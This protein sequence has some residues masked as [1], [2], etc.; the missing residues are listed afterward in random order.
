VAQSAT[1]RSGAIVFMTQNLAAAPTAWQLK[2]AHPTTGVVNV[3]PSMP[4][5]PASLYVAPT[6][7][8]VWSYTD[9][10]GN[11]VVNAAAFDGTTLTTATTPLTVFA[12]TTPGNF[13]V[14]RPKVVVGTV[15]AVTTNV[16]S[17]FVADLTKMTVTHPVAPGAMVGGIESVQSRN[18]YGT[19][20][21]TISDDQLKV[22]FV[23]GD[24]VAS[25]TAHTV[26]V[27]D[28]PSGM[29]SAIHASSALDMSV[30]TAPQWP[31]TAAGQA[32]AGG[33]TPPSGPA[34]AAG[35]VFA[36]VIT[37][38]SPRELRLS[39][40]HYD[41]SSAAPTAEPVDHPALAATALQPVISG[42]GQ[43]VL[44]AGR[45]G[46][47]LAIF[48]AAI[49]AASGTITAKRVLADASGPIV[50]HEG[51]G[52][53]LAQDNLGTIYM[54]QLTAGSDPVFKPVI[55][56]TLPF[57]GFSPT[58]GFTPDGDHAW[59]AQ[60][61]DTTML[62]ATFILGGVLE[63]I[64]LNTGTRTNLGSIAVPFFAGTPAAAFLSGGLGVAM[65]P[66]FIGTSS[67]PL[68]ANGTT[69]VFA[70]LV[71]YGGAGMSL[72]TGVDGA[73]GITTNGLQFAVSNMPTFDGSQFLVINGVMQNV[74]STW[75]PNALDYSLL[76]LGGAGTVHQVWMAGASPAT[77]LS[78]G[79]GAVV[80]GSQRRTGANDAVLLQYQSNGDGTGQYH[81]E[82]PANGR[83]PADPPVY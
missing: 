34:G 31:H 80:M 58:F 59:V 4:N 19:L 32:L 25:G 65:S 82:A 10:G 83:A 69:Q 22:A 56:G 6:G 30:F 68:I 50:L 79:S 57:G 9:G 75:S 39:I 67:V 60:V 42:G 72:A 21:F 43:V 49:G 73:S 16:S 55:D 45:D 47:N 29:A 26:R 74:T 14:A 46:S 54:A 41:G 38:A 17:L 3:G 24:P 77:I 23:T 12:S 52:R 51:K 35:L 64:D 70:P 15:G 40:A 53:A 61:T 63:T 7:E 71:T 76:D 66:P 37:T 20:P 27:V 78:A 36:D 1:T 11:R 48:S 8:I 18:I 5:L 62:T 44:F 81:Y 2:L 28:L 33:A 13:N